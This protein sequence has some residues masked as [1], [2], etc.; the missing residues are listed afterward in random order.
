VHANLRWGVFKR[1]SV[2]VEYMAGKQRIVDETE[3]FGQRI[4]FGAKLNFTD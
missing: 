4:Q 1:F 3:G 2:G